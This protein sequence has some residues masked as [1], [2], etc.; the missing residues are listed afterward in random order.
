[1]RL[2]IWHVDHFASTPGQRGR[3]AVADEQPWPVAIDEG[4]LIFAAS[5]PADDADPQ[6]TA[7]RATEAIVKAAAQ[8][9][10]KAIVLHSFAHLFGEL[11]S[12]EGA[13]VVLDATQAALIARGFTCQQTPFGWFNALDIQAKGHPYSRMARTV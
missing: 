4:L 10:A 13:R 6:A 8:V 12:P 5:E 9:K 3:S 2:L 11:G 1:M 7:A